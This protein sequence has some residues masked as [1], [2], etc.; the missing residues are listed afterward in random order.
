ML[1]SLSLSVVAAAAAVVVVIIALGEARHRRGRR[2]WRYNQVVAM[3]NM[4]DIARFILGRS[5][6]VLRIVSH[7]DCGEEFCCD[8]CCELVLCYNI[9]RNRRTGNYNNL[10]SV[11]IAYSSSARATYLL[12]K[13]D[14]LLLLLLQVCCFVLGL[15]L[16]RYQTQ[17]PTKILCAYFSDCQNT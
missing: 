15:L 7:Y 1:L 4:I 8:F 17:M 10:S 6:R 11:V 13:I 12:G 16:E 5:D 2:T 3:I 9:D 14:Y